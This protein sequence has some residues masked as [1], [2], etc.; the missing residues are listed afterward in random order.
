MGRTK[1]YLVE[2]HVIFESYFRPERNVPA[3]RLAEIW[4]LLSEL[5]TLRAEAGI[6]YQGS[7]NNF[8][9]P[10]ELGSPQMR[11]RI[12]NSNDLIT[13]VGASV[14][15][16]DF[17][18]DA[19]RD[20]DV[21]FLY[22]PH[23]VWEGSPTWGHVG[24][25]VSGQIFEQVSCDKILKLLR[26]ILELL[27]PATP[28]FALIDIAPADDGLAGTV[29]GTAWPARAPLH[30]LIEA[31]GWNSSAFL[32]GDRVRGLYWGN[33][34]GHEVLDRLGGLDRFSAEFKMHARYA[35]G[36][37]NAHMWKFNDGLLITLS[38]NPLDCRP[39]DYA[40]EVEANLIWVMEELGRAG[41]L[42][43]W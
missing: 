25:S 33:Y 2:Y 28:Q 21:N 24:L 32:K 38:M 26:R 36:S 27:E 16:T 12:E 43:H 17:A 13:L 23:G 29:Y 40:P 6:S 3:Q 41:V 5:G 10:V 37:A 7:T 39:E 15:R 35:D 1:K 19:I 8:C 34:Y 14:A 4:G 18:R 9:G 20:S 30:R 31:H 11:D 22:S 42:S